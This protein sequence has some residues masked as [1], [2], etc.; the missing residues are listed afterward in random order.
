MPPEALAEWEEFKRRGY[1]KQDHD[2]ATGETFETWPEGIVLNPDHPLY[3]YL[4][5]TARPENWREK[6]FIKGQPGVWPRFQ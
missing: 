1:P 6:E 2:P 3:E 5:E 4:P